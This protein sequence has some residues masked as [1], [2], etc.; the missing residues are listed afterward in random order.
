MKILITGARQGIGRDAAFALSQRGHEVIATTRTEAGATDLAFEAKEL[1]ITLQTAKLDILHPAD[2]KKALSFGVDVLINNAGVGQSGPLLEI[3]MKLVRE[4]FETNV[5]ATLEL[6]QEIGKDMLKNGS[7]RIL[8]VSSVAG[9]MTLPYLGAYSMTKHA[10][11]S[12]GDALRQELYHHGI[13]VSL[14]EPGA[15][16]TGFNEKMNDS[17]YQ[18]FDKNSP[19]SADSK[20]IKQYEKLLTRRASGSSTVVS[21][22]IHAVESPR[23]KARYVRPR[24]ILAWL[25]Q[26]VPSKL[27]DLLI[28]SSI[29]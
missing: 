18:W 24:S 25:S 6:T 17:K 5:F 19:F 1:G 20:D 2:R 4:N 26:A 3:P 22:I 27:R 11:E 9:R 7:G 16:S 8:I 14:I 23:P 13:H 15:I 29:K 10:L 28:R 21:A 12:M